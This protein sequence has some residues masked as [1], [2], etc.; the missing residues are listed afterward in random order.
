MSYC[1]TCRDFS[2]VVCLTRPGFYCYGFGFKCYF[3]CY[4][5]DP[6]LPLTDG[7]TWR[8][9]LSKSFLFAADQ[10]TLLNKAICSAKVT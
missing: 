2:I 10:N 8:G 3:Y 6:F 1:F 9:F 4:C 5:R 7:V